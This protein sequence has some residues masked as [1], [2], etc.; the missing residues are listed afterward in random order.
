VHQALAYLFRLHQPDLIIYDAV[1]DIHADDNLGYLD[2]STTGIFAR[3][4]DV[5]QQAKSAEI[6]IACV[7]GGG[8]SN[9]K[10]LLNIRHSQLFLA[11]NTVW[12]E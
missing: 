1:V 4:E 8:Y 3:D 10:D 9:D 12:S 5:I 2:I 11:A 7:I 6:P